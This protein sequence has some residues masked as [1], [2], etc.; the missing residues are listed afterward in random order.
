MSFTYISLL[1]G[2]N[3]SGQKK[4]PMKELAKVYEQLGYQGVKTYIQS[5]NV[6]F[7]TGEDNMAELSKK[8]ETTIQQQFEFDV[9]VLVKTPQAL[10]N[11]IL[12]NPFARERTFVTFL[13]QLPK[14][15]PLDELN[16]AKQAGEELMVKRDV[17][18]FCCPDNY[19]KSKLSN[20]FF[21]TKLK[22]PAT[23]RNWK[24]VNKLFELASK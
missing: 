23:T 17:V 5:G 6:I 13:F 10:Q 22:V 8:I 15:I 3:V 9:K 11:V 21:E 20:N 16:Q 2:I 4:I 12:E 19:G 14:T 18:Y 7:T 1:R 24:T